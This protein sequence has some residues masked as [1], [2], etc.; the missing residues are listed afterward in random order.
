MKLDELCAVLEVFVQLR[1]LCA[2][3]GQVRVDPLGERLLLH[4]GTTLLSL[5]AVRELFVGLGQRLLDRRRGGRAGQGSRH[6]PLLYLE[7]A[8]KPRVARLRRQRDGEREK[9]VVIKIS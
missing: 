3:L 9:K 8:Y 6:Y 2:D 7:S 5:D 1:C 4:T